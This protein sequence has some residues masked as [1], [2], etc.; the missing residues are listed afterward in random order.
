MTISPNFDTRIADKTI[1]IDR[2]KCRWPK[3]TE[4]EYD[5]RYSLVR[6]FMREKDID[7]LLIGGGE[8]HYG[9]GWT[10][11]RWITNYYDYAAY[12]YVVFPREGDLTLCCWFNNPHDLAASVIDDVRADFDTAK[13][14]VNRIKELGLDKGKIAVVEHCA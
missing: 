14:A 2:E 4:R 7:C 10:N 11:I 6:D 8:T 9:K 5:R 3:F 13:I 1:T 12:A